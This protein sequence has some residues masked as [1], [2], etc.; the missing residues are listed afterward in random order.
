[1]VYKLL[2]RNKNVEIF[3]STGLKV[4]SDSEDKPHLILVSEKT[5]ET[6]ALS[7]PMNILLKNLGEMGYIEYKKDCNKNNPPCV[8]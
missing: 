4:V 2:K 6:L 5:K 8:V 1:M 3:P 7:I